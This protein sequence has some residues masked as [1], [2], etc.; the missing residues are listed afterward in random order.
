MRYLISPESTHALEFMLRKAQPQILFGI[1]DDF[2]RSK[3]I[4]SVT[5]RRPCNARYIIDIYLGTQR[6]LVGILLREI[7]C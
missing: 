3:L 4:L 2:E 5:K 6:W 1:L 7:V